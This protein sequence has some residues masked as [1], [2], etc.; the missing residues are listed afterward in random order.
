MMSG[1]KNCTVYFHYRIGIFSIKEI[2]ISNFLTFYEIFYD[3]FLL[4]A[5][6]YKNNKK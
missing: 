2:S 1:S 5:K 3:L 6:Q 4:T